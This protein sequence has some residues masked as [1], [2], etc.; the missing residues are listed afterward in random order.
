MTNQWNVKLTK[1][2]VD[3]MASRWKGLAPTKLC[4]CISIFFWGRMFLLRSADEDVF[5]DFVNEFLS[6]F[7]AKVI[8]C[9]CHKKY[10]DTYWCLGQGLEVLLTSWA[11]VINIFAT[12][13][14]EILYWGLFN[15]LD[16]GY[17]IF[18][19][20]KITEIL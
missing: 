18:F 1:W 17:K 6:T 2:Q 5:R 8:K 10:K 19:A 15:I 13:I 20:T 9:F 3:K 7:W 14:R 4:H 11:K 16:Q 12:K